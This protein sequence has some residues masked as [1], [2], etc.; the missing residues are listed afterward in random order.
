[1]PPQSS[2]MGDEILSKQ[3]LR[4]CFPG[5]DMTGSGGV[6]RGVAWRYGTFRVTRARPPAGTKGDVARLTAVWE[7]TLATIKDIINNP[8]R[9]S[10]P[11]RNNGAH[12]DR[13]KARIVV[14]PARRRCPVSL[15]EAE[16]VSVCSRAEEEKK[17]TGGT[18]AFKVSY[19]R[20]RKQT[21]AAT[22]ELLF[23]SRAQTAASTARQAPVDPV[24]LFIP[25]GRSSRSLCLRTHPAP[26]TPHTR[27][28][29]S[30]AGF[31]RATLTTPSVSECTRP[32]Q[33]H[34][35]A[36]LS[37]RLARFQT[38]DS[39]RGCRIKSNLRSRKKK[40]REFTSEAT[41]VSSANGS[42]CLDGDEK[43]GERF[44]SVQPLKVWKQ[45]VLFATKTCYKLSFPIAQGWETSLLNRPG[46]SHFLF[47]ARSLDPSSDFKNFTLT[48]G[49]TRRKTAKLSSSADVRG[50]LCLQDAVAP[51][52]CVLRRQ[53]QQFSVTEKSENL[54]EVLKTRKRSSISPKTR[55]KKVKV[56]PEVTGVDRGALDKSREL[57]KAA[58]EGDTGRVKQLLAE[59]VNP[60]AGGGYRNGSSLHSAAYHGHRG[61]VSAL[62]RAG[63]DVNAWDNKQGKRTPLHKAA[64][65]GHH[66]TVSVLLKAGADVDPQN[67]WECTALHLA[68][69]QGHP[70]CAEILLQHGADTA[71][72]N[73]KGRTA[74]EIA[75]DENT[76][77]SFAHMKHQK[78]RVT[79]G[80]KE[81]L[82]LLKIFREHKDQWKVLHKAAYNGHHETVSALL[83]S[84]VDVNTR[85][86]KQKTPL[87]LAAENGHH[88]TVSAL[89]SSGADVNARDNEQSSPLHDA[90]WNGHHETVSALL[91]AGA[92]VN[93]WDNEQRTPL[94]L[95]AYNGHHGTVSALLTAGADV[96][97]RND[98]QGT[99]LHWAAGNGHHETV[100]A[101]LTA[102]ADVNARDNEE[103]TPLHD[104]ASRG[105][106]KCVEILLQ[107]GA[108]TGIRNEK[109][110]TAEDIAADGDTTG[111]FANNKDEEKRIIH[112]RKEILRLLREQN[113]RVSKRKKGF[114]PVLVRYFEEGMTKAKKDC[115]S[116]QEAAK[117]SGKTEEEVR[118]FIGNYRKSLGD[119]KQRQ[120]MATDDTAAGYSGFTGYHEDSGMLEE[121]DEFEETTAECLAEQQESCTL[122]LTHE[123]VE[124]HSDR[125]SPTDEG[126][127]SQESVILISD[128]EET[129]QVQLAD[130]SMIVR[131]EASQIQ[132]KKGGKRKSKTRHIGES[133]DSGPLVKRPK[134]AV[135]QPG[136][137]TIA[138]ATEN[139][140]KI[141]WTE[142]DSY[143]ISISPTDGTTAPSNSGS[144][145]TLEHTFTGLTAGTEYTISVVTVSD[146]ENSVARTET[147]RT[148]VAQPGPITIAEETENSIR[149][150]WTEAVGAKDSYDI[151][152]SPDTGVT[153]PSANVNSGDPLEHTFTG[154][155]AGTEYTISV[156]TVSGGENS[157]A[158][159]ETRRTTVAQPGPITIAEATENSIRITWT[160]ATGTK[161]SYDISITPDTGVTNPSASVN[162][163]GPLEHTFTG[164]TAGTE[165]TISVVTVSGGENSSPTA[166]TQRTKF[167]SVLFVNRKYG[168]SH[169]GPSTTNREIA[170]FLQGHGA[171]VHATALQ[172]SEDDKNRY[173]DIP[174]D[175]NCIV[176]HVDVTSEAA[177]SIQ[178]DRCQHAKLILF[179][180]DMP[181]DTEYYKGSEK[182]M[183]AGK[184]MDDILEDTKNA[185]AVFSLGRRIYDYFETKYRSLGER[186]PT[187]HF[188]FLPRPSPVFEA[189]SVRP[190]GRQKVVL[191]V[192]RV[193]EVDKLKG[194]DVIARAMGEV[195]EKITNV[196]LR[197]RGI[198]EDDYEASK[199]IL[200][201][202]L[203]SG[204]IKPTLRPCGTQEDIAQEMKQAH[205]VVMPS[206]A[207]PF[208]LIGLEAIAAGIP[209]LISD[210]SGLAD[211]IMD[212]I[213]K[214]KC[215]ADMRHRIVE[216]S[217]RE[218]D[219]DVAAKEWA[220]RI[221]DTL[222]HSKHE[223]DRAAEYKK[224]LLESKYWE[225]SHQNLLRVCG[226]I[227]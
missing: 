164:L 99:P 205:L 109:G 178:E 208:G 202:N 97:A 26:L 126:E 87:H 68:A 12:S 14:G 161:D 168:T 196:S 103:S 64:A 94:Y 180:H 121:P 95:A 224:K 150:T 186:K 183:A 167:T 119:K 173:P 140:I 226:L 144:V 128:E 19:S 90:A 162:S 145:N 96:N 134:Q 55:L 133:S 93:A 179:N 160:D 170:Q 223:F 203:R 27:P 191:S 131:S 1:L 220:K 2:K 88:E 80:R 39:A 213:E 15:P 65:N 69:I 52:L 10:R 6:P 187:K 116:I 194:H 219:L 75:A 30:P 115:P 85:D 166:K 37:T 98:E 74:E 182:A 45:R 156:V 107:H 62:L 89:L 105:H 157:V 199:K 136:P 3:R 58:L 86:N 142:A 57:R 124:Q 149:I 211:M 123:A 137:I 42:P 91:T 165:Y 127:T 82:R 206:R 83:S 227:D 18:G 40:T 92:D 192:G 197:V 8:C 11:V 78:E 72:R 175:L 163:G 9:P 50:Q 41:K 31:H 22:C 200:E 71:L 28:A 172:A 16:R 23:T 101:L 48:Q 35:H 76:Q 49:L 135:A 61:T 218:S 190:G 151:S 158:R 139:S 184:K 159:T 185:D 33:L 111:A 176:G 141:T 46:L 138:E 110:R 59:G 29:N 129:S 70:K 106:P 155:T 143:R 47:F 225:E 73:E 63:A 201:E 207:E 210:K 44:R 113:N 204:N 4:V 146:G 108:D 84:G 24:I 36:P 169:G 189:I 38:A 20:Q 216:T 174:H 148:T 177:K 125:N 102:G 7:G 114:D 215:P 53:S 54:A 66:E 153:N 193:T 43:S 221:V 56:N 117:A 209:V 34:T 25:P 67:Q 120:A 214:E 13:E 112:G 181:E 5:A 104:A 171:T 17:G 222:K 188:L 122:S 77:G 195:A 217:V 60:D 118:T 79:R 147:R 154:L 100:S 130:G 152:I 81:I 132:A 198:D 51:H 21:G 212:L 32:R